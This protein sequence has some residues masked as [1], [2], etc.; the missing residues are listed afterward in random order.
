MTIEA[1]ATAAASRPDRSTLLIYLS[2]LTAMF[3]AV[4]DM[5]IVVTAMPT[6]AHDL[7]DVSLLG[8]VGAA[9]L[10]SSAAVSPFYGKLGDMY[11]RKSIVVFAVA[12][13][14]A[15]SLLCGLAW[16]MP[17]LIA[18]RVVQGIG[19]GGLMVS[20]FAIIG[21]LF[22]PRER[23]KYQGYSSIV[24]TVGTVVGPVGGGYLT[25]LFGWRSVFLV[26]MPIGV[27]VLAAILLFMQRKPATAHHKVDILGGV[28][29]AIGTVAI[30]NWSNHVLEA[31]VLDAWNIALPL[32][33]IAAIIAC[34]L[35]ERR[36]AEPIVPLR[37]FANRTI[38]LVVIASV[39]GGMVTLGLYFYFALFMQMITQLA[40]GPL[41]LLFLPMSVAVAVTSV[42]AGWLMAATGRYKW[43]PVIGMALGVFLMA[44]YA[45]MDDHTPLWLIGLTYL[46]FG[47]SMGLTMQTLLVA[48]QTAA[49]LKDIGAAT[50]LA[51]QAR[52]IGASL[53]HRVNGGVMAMA[54][55]HATA[56][57]PANVAS[58]LPGGLAGLTPKGLEALPASVRELALNA[59]AHGFAPTYWVAGGL[60]LAATVLLLFLPNNQIPKHQ[61]R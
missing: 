36:A 19:G 20:A 43:L 35:V 46:V 30:V 42:A 10:L 7:G 26:N 60:Y 15:G 59:Y 22:E 48:I 25:D 49:P 29:L 57:L 8:W 58:A 31:P 47:I 28:L 24:F 21:E 4:L 6:I 53:G 11:G 33:G 9:Y 52:T 41:G 12:A 3:M 17:A 2:A 54:L 44:G 18:A 55:H 37:L 51:T 5:N 45:L 61:G 38:S 27:L 40:P 56:A 50:G 1:Q 39:L 14:L 23:A 34:I 32:V 13:F 16:S